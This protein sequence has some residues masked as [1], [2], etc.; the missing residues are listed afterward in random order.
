LGFVRKEDGTLF[1]F[2]KTPGYETYRG[3]GWYG[4]ISLAPPSS[5]EAARAMEPAGAAAFTESADR[6]EATAA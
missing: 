5:T 6:T 2:A 3:M 1:G 4:V